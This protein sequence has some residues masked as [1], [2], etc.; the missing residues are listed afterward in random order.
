MH[1]QNHMDVVA[2]DGKCVNSGRKNITQF[3]NARLQPRF[4]VFKIFL[5][6]R[7]ES[8]QPRAAHAAANQVEKP[9]LGWVD[10][11]AARLGHGLSLGMRNASQ[12]T[13][14]LK[15]DSDLSAAIAKACALTLGAQS[16]CDG[17]ASQLG[18]YT[19]AAQSFDGRQQVIIAVIAVPGA[20]NEVSG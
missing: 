5:G 11:L 13:I 10:E 3:Q 8:T 15:L 20:R 1:V 9:R 6:V 17:I 7:I 19:A 18:F 16:V 12:N 2:H 14:A 4:A